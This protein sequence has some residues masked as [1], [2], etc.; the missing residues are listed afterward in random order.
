LAAQINPQSWDPSVKSLC[1]FPSVLNTMSES[2]AW[3]SALGEAYYNSP[4]T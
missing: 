3:T 1:Q 4:M 2:L